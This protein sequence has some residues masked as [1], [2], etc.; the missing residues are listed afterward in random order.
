LDEISTEQPL[1]LVVD[2]YADAREMYVEYLGFSGY[3]TA[4]A[5]DGQEA[6]DKTLALQPAV[7]LM[8][9]SLPVVDGWEATRQLKA[10]KRTRHIPIVALT[11][12]ALEGNEEE[13]RKAGCDDF[14]AKPCL[15]QDLV[16]KIVHLLSKPKGRA[17]P[18]SKGKAPAAEL[19]RK[20]R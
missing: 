13:A 20:R 5:V 14:I 1:I 10:D 15:P 18:K 19:K 11:G 6:I 12:H 8:D 16:A 4:E 7:V 3:R 17:R 9:L 2:D